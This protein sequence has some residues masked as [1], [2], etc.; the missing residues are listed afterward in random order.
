MPTPRMLMIL[1]ENWTITDGRNLNDLYADASTPS[2][3]S[4]MER[5]FA[6]G[7]REFFKL[8]EKRVVDT[9]ALLDSLGKVQSKGVQ[10]DAPG[11]SINAVGKFIGH[12]YHGGHGGSLVTGWRPPAQHCGTGTGGA[13]GQRFRGV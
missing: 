1:S 11:V 8:R 10:V 5:I 7:M 2:A 9:G 13:F 12:T 6:S 3:S 4:P